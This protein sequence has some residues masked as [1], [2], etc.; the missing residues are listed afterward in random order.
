MSIN[1]IPSLFVLWVV[2]CFVL[3]CGLEPAEE[4]A[5][6]HQGVSTPA[7][8]LLS[9]VTGY[10]QSA[11][12]VIGGGFT[13]GYIEV[14]NIAYHKKV[15]VHY[16]VSGKPDWLDVDA[17]YVGPSSGNREVWTFKTPDYPH[18]PRLATDF[19]FAI[20][21]TVA[22]QTYWDNNSGRDYRVGIGPRPVF[23]R[24]AL[25]GASVD[26]IQA[27]AMHGKLVVDIA[28]KN[29][30]YHKKVEVVYTVDD[31]ATS[32]VASASYRTSSWGCLDYGDAKY[33]EQWRLD[34]PI[35]AGTKRVKL[36]ISYTVGGVTHWDNNQ[37]AD[38]TVDM[39]GVTYY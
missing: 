4:V 6:I 21:Y 33:L 19:R 30:A 9:A 25:S 15:V 38:Y 13:Q 10:E 18:P 17:T 7:V 5:G 20:R 14:E 26:L 1:A 23:P 2:T 32:K 12:G 34:T 31:W 3:G 24:V 28:V 11:S 27:E 39:P 35:P 29:V 16:G 37:K 8:R 22:G 36:A